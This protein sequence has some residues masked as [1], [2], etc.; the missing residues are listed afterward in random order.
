MGTTTF[1]GEEIIF[2]LFL[3]EN[4]SCCYSLDAPWRGASNEYRSMFS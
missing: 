2:F 1:F 4:I 3:H